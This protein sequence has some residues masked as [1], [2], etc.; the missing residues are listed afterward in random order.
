MAVCL[1]QAGKARSAAST[2]LVVSSAPSCGTFASSM[3]VAGLF[4]AK[5]GEPTQAPSM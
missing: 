4:T 1:A 2:A 3:P 5:T